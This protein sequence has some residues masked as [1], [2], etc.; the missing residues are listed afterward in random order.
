[1]RFKGLSPFRIVRY[2]REGDHPDF[3][4]PS[5]PLHGDII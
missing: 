2:H 3:P 4:I 5:D 1:M